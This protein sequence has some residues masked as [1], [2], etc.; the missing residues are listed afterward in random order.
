M[1]RYKI[2]SHKLIYHIP[3]VYD[4][5]KG[6]DIF[7]IYAEVGLYGG[8]NHRCIFCAV[9]FLKYEPQ[10]LDRK[11]LENFI[12]DA[13][14]SGLRSILYSGEGE[15]LLH[16]D[17]TDI[18]GST[19]KAGIDVALVSNGVFLDRDRAKILLK[20]L[21]WIKISIDAGTRGAYSV[22]HGAEP[23]DFDIVLGNLKGAVKIR[24]KYRYSC[25]IGTQLLMLPQNFREIIA[26]AKLMRRMKVDYL[27][28]KPY[29]RHP[30]SL[31]RIN[32]DFNSQELNDLEQR[33]QEY[34]DNR[35]RIILRKNAARKI[36]DIKPYAYC[37]GLPFAVHVTASGD[38]YP[39]NVFL[40][41]EEFI[42]GNLCKQ[43]FKSI[44]R[45]ERRKKI[46]KHIDK[47]WDI[48]DCRSACR[49]DEINRYLWEL[50][51]PPPQVNFI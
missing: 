39:C 46:M 45:S 35:F 33:L 27:V 18:V 17:A 43:S 29:C 16:K 15:P 21:S 5:L 51:N 7:P 4:W 24:D 32:P 30:S 49:L 25:V 8:C 26:L 12:R 20:Y 34:A 1:D 6:R 50:K 36:N 3:R 14:E 2:D 47:N 19:R 10:A 31:H 28:I 38:V 40:G 23:D 9:D 11:C 41:K 37:L 44:W 48:M 13:R 42:F 22:V